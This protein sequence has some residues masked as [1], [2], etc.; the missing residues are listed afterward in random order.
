MNEPDSGRHILRAPSDHSCRAEK[1][2]HVGA[3]AAIL[4]FDDAVAIAARRQN[5]ALSWP[6]WNTDARGGKRARMRDI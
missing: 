4:D 1:V 6:P 2:P 5:A 3:D